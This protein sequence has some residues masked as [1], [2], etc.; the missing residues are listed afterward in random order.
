[1][2]QGISRRSIARNRPG[3]LPWRRATAA[4]E[5][6]EVGLKVAEQAEPLRWGGLVAHVVGDAGEAVNGRQVLTVL[7]G[8]QAQR[9]REI[10]RGGLIGGRH[11]NRRR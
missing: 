8:Q 3:P 6:A 5:P 10:L 2:A 11:L 4:V 9:D 7:P 1:M